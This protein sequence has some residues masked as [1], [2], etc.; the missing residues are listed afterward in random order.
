MQPRLTSNC[1]S[2]MLRRYWIIFVL[3]LKIGIN[4]HIEEE[5]RV[6]CELFLT[7]LFFCEDVS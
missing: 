5:S 3:L 7:S 4:K 6:W 1:F 2:E